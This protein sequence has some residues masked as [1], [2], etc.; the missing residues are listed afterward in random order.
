MS[1]LTT[2][3]LSKRQQHCFLKS[4]DHSARAAIMEKESPDATE[5]TLLRALERRYVRYAAWLF[6]ANGI[7]EPARLPS[8]PLASRGHRQHNRIVEATA[9]HSLSLAR[10]FAGE[11]DGDHR[12]NQD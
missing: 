9:R 11:I 8:R 7:T 2:P 1:I 4:P 6:R 12:S 3:V 10:L 5:D